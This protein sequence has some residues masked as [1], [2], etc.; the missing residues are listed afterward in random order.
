[1]PA[2]SQSFGSWRLA[3]FALRRGLNSGGKVYESFDQE[4]FPISPCWLG[5]LACD[6]L[7]MPSLDLMAVPACTHLA[8]SHT[9]APSGLIAF[10]RCCWNRRGIYHAPC[11][12][13]AC[14]FSCTSNVTR[15]DEASTCFWRCCVPDV[16]GTLC[17]QVS[18]LRCLL[19]N[20]V[21]ANQPQVV[22]GFLEL[23][24]QQLLSSPEAADWHVWF[25]LPYCKAPASHP[26]FQ[27]IAALRVWVC[28]SA[29]PLAAVVSLSR[30]CACLLPAIRQVQQHCFPAQLL[31]P[32][33]TFTH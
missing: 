27:V 14:F 32:C 29:G 11:V 9:P 21:Q 23:H 2:T 7:S 13:C 33:S 8:S 19:V 20:A 16:A 15:P 22:T 31:T 3:C 18:I 4:S 1:M 30:P 26:R 25:A 10:H 5:C 12:A 6:R 17:L 28:G 24:S